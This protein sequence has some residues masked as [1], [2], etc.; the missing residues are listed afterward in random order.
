M[1][2]A[3][4]LMPWTAS[5][6]KNVAKFVTSGPR[7]WSQYYSDAGPIFLRITNVARSRIDLLLADLQRVVPPTNAEGVRTIVEAGDILVSI[8]AD[9]GSVGIVPE[10]LG[11]A[12]VS[13][14][15]ALVRLNHR[16]VDPRFVAYS[17]SS[18]VSQRYLEES[19]QGG[20]KAGLNLDDVRDLPI[21]L[22]QLVYQKVI[23]S[24]LDRKTAAIDALIEKKRKLVEL[25]AEKRAALINQA[26]TKGLDPTVPMKDSGI[27]W[28]GKIPAHWK[29]KRTRFLCRKIKTGTTPPT[30]E[31]LWYT[32]GEVP[33]YAPSSFSS[34][35]L[36]LSEPKALLNPDVWKYKLVPRFALGTVLIVG[37]G[38]TLGKVAHLEREGSANQQVL[39]LEFCPLVMNTRFAAYQ[40]KYREAVFRDLAQY[41]T[42]PIMNQEGVAD[43][44]AVCP[45][46]IEQA[47]IV[48]YLDG[49]TQKTDQILA[50]CGSQLSL[51][52]EYRQ[53]LITAA[54]TGQLE[55]PEEPQE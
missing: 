19:M 30:S 31:P 49:N 11:S 52:Q 46:L 41:T 37:I 34:D 54:V 3:Q 2:T 20:T 45:P 13:Q 36:D 1:T 25:L 6:L 29:T 42:L 47:E 35:G 53:A 38:A 8:T 44:V 23:S 4:A 17:L 18:K 10:G 32:E 33:W 28:I 55:I 51:L 16:L 14:H 39:A 26:V 24:Y 7:G 48:E 22:P 27:P 12:Y 15:L 43:H 21:H 5:R 9:I 50:I 40:F